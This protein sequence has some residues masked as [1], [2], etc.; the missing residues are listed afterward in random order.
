MQRFTYFFAHKHCKCTQT[1]SL[2]LHY[3][4]LLENLSSSLSAFSPYFMDFHGLYLGRQCFSTGCLFR[5][6]CRLPRCVLW[7]NG[8][9]Y[10]YSVYRGQIGILSWHFG[11]YIFWPPPPPPTREFRPDGG[12]YRSKLCIDRY[13][14]VVDGLL[15]PATP[16]PTTP[17]PYLTPKLHITK[18]S[19]PVHLNNSGIFCIVSPDVV[20]NHIYNTSNIIA[21][22]CLQTSCIK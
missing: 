10:A 11:G 4:W 2:Y 21:A 8:A 3:I 12:R 1:L 7:P 18:L 22:N 20:W 13:W 19:S 16:D 9:R 15:I 14:E 17:P 6:L 5:S